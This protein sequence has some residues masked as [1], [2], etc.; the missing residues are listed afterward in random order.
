MPDTELERL[1]AQVA[2]EEARLREIEAEQAA[3]RQRLKALSAQ[4]GRLQHSV[5]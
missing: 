4:L 3:A 2:R 1:A 5:P